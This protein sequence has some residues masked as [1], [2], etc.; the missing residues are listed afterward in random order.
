MATCQD[1]LDPILTENAAINAQFPAFFFS[2]TNCQGLRYP[3]EG[4]FN[5]WNQDLSPST[6]GFSQINSIF[7]PPQ[8]ILELWSPGNN[9]Y[10]SFPGPQVIPVTSAQLVLWSHWDGSP[11]DSSSEL[12]CNKKIDWTVGSGIARIR[13]TIQVPWTT[14]LHNMASNKQVL[15][16]NGTTYPTDNDT[17]F[18]ELCRDPENRYSCHCQWAYEEILASHSAAANSSYVNLLQNG[19]NPNTQYVPTNALVASGTVAECQ[20]MIQAQLKT[21]TFPLLGTPNGQ[22]NYICGNQIYINAY[23][24]GISDPLTRIDDAEDDKLETQEMTLQETPAYAWWIL[25]VLLIVAFLCWFTYS[26]HISLQKSHHIRRSIKHNRL[27]V[28]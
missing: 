11:C 26:L 14:L 13:F 24:D 4:S 28:S 6:I 21:G 9:G 7:V 3:A 8:I 15:Q 27:T 1:V 10:V 12:Y 5:L 22:Q 25:A 2:G 20:T 16:W 23:S 19:C 17:L 18:N